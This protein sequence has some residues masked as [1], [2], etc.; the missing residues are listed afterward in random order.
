M[1][2]QQE[3]SLLCKDAP[4]WDVCCIDVRE[5]KELFFVSGTNCSFWLLAW[6]CSWKSPGS[7]CSVMPPWD[8]TEDPGEFCDPEVLLPFRRPSKPF[9]DRAAKGLPNLHSTVMAQ[10][11]FACLK[12]PSLKTSLGFC[13]HS[14]A[15][16]TM[17]L[18]QAASDSGCQCTDKK[19]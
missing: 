19:N 9:C 11:V 1:I 6:M 8:G 12:T 17:A 18:F 15:S 2:E 16:K 5:I 3:A 13:L 4:E 14:I 10:P 7:C